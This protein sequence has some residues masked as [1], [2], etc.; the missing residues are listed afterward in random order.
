MRILKSNPILSLA[1]S[2][3]IDSP[4]PA[5]ISYMWNFGSLLGVC[6]IIQILTGVF[7]AMHYCGNVELAF[8][9]VEHIMRDVNYGWF[10][11]YCHA[12]VA[13]FFFTFL[14]IHTA[15]GLYYSSYKTPRG[16]LWSIGVII[17]ILTM[18]T[19]FLGYV[20]PYGQMSLWGYQYIA[21]HVNYLF[22]YFID[23][24]ILIPDFKIYF[25]YYVAYAKSICLFHTV[26]SPTVQRKG[27][28]LQDKIDN[29]FKSNRHYSTKIIPL[30]SSKTVRIRADKR[31]GPH[32]YEIISIIFGVLLGN[33]HAEKR[34]TGCGTRITFFQEGSHVSY[35]LWLHNLISDLGYCNS[36]I[37]KMQTRLGKQGIV[38]RII[39]FSTWTYSSF[40]WI[41]ELWYFSNSSADSMI[42][43]GRNGSVRKENYTKRIPENLS[44]F[45]TP[46]SLAIWIMDDGG[47]VGSGLKFATNS[48]SYSDCLFLVKILHDKFFIKA[49]VQS[50]G[51]KDQYLIYIWKESMPLLRELVT[52]YLHPSMKYKIL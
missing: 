1:N 9:S 52:P 23:H 16:L 22:Y 7:L 14:Y 30:V 26:L 32:N 29:R 21:L 17:L 39:R 35:L 28:V 12:N 50:A 13:S 40:N 18:A 11:R 45:L 20:L 3:L 43:T 34:I 6:L 36:N 47:K 31:I 8:V 51:V 49:S 42:L 27:T 48:Y 38:R 4:Q 41:H 5:N 25:P 24:N 19:A 46:L 10:L 15:R 2:Y 33:G 44:L 37:P